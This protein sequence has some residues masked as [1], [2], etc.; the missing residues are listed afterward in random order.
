MLCV[1]GKTTSFSFVIIMRG[2]WAIHGLSL[3]ALGGSVGLNCDKCR[4]LFIC[5][6]GQTFL[7]TLPISSV[8]RDAHDRDVCPHYLTGER[9]A[10]FEKYYTLAHLL[11]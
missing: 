1:I 9:S 11:R 7:C 6:S 5:V 8:L 2:H 4:M 3:T 10:S